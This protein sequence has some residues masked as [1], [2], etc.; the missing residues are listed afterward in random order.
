MEM[1]EKV[2]EPSGGGAL[3]EEESISLG[4]GLSLLHGHTCCSLAL[5]P[6]CGNSVM[7]QL[8]ALAVMQSLPSWTLRNHKLK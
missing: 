8:R 2:M 7:R 6:E 5:F 1:F 4:W 3:M